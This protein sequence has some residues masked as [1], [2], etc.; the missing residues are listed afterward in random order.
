[1]FCSNCGKEI[2]T[3]AAFCPHCGTN[4]STGAR[5]TQETQVTVKLASPNLLKYVRFITLGVGVILLIDAIDKWS[6]ISKVLQ[7]LT[8]DMGSFAYK[9]GK[10]TGNNMDYALK[11]AANDAGL[12]T[13]LA[14]ALIMIGG[15]WDKLLAK[16][17]RH[18]AIKSIYYVIAPV[19]YFFTMIFVSLFIESFIGIP[20]V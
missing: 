16:P 17:E 7:Y 11:D 1:M 4:V 5:N 14:V 3:T 18:I 19:C 6:D 2:G 20:Q 10:F 8:T 13:M 15:F 9:M 12:M